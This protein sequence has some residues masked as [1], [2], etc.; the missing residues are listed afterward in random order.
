MPII[1][2]NVESSANALLKIKARTPGKA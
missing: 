2:P 1:P